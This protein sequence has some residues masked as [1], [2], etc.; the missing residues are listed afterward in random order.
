MMERPEVMSPERPPGAE[1]GAARTEDATTP[2][3]APLPRT[4]RDGARAS[5]GRDVRASLHSLV[6]VVVITAAA[7]ALY[8]SAAGHADDAVRVRVLPIPE[9]QSPAEISNAVEALPPN[10]AGL[11][12]SLSTTGSQAVDEIAGLHLT[13]LQVAWAEIGSYA[14]GKIFA[15]VSRG[16]AEGPSA[17]TLVARMAQRI[18]EGGSSFGLPTQVRWADGVWTTSGVGQVHYFFS[19]GNQVWWLSSQPELGRTALTDLLGRVR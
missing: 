13:G 19:A 1:R 3:P 17:S 18:G 6:V 15:W 5:Q 14:Q 7:T 4:G 9:A 16:P 8:L 12:L 11:P 2:L 10:L